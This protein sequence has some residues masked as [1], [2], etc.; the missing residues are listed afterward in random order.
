L[1]I[2]QAQDKE[3]DWT[4]LAD[5]TARRKRQNRLNQRAYSG[6]DDFFLLMIY[7]KFK[8]LTSW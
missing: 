1:K 7:T 8:K 2:P 6:F 3:D 4:G 5:A